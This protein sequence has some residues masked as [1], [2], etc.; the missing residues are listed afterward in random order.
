MSNY[1]KELHLPKKSDIITQ[2][3]AFELKVFHKLL[4]NVSLLRVIFYWS[5]DSDTV[6]LDRK[7]SD[8]RIFSDTVKL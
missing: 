2:P 4:I 1:S 3:G 8:N 7:N 5:L 6:P